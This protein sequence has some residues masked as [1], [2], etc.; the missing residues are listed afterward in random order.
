MTAHRLLSPRDFR[1]MP[2]KNGGG[3]TAEIVS[4]DARGQYGTVR[5]ARL[6]RRD[7]AGRPFSAWPGIDR[8]FVLLGGAGVVLTQGGIDVGEVVARHEP[9]RFAGDEASS[10]RLVDGPARAFNLMVRRGHARGTS[11]S[12][13]ARRR[14]RAVPLRRLLRGRGGERVPAAGPRADRDRRGHALL[15]DGEDRLASM[16][17]NPIDTGAVAIVAALDAASE[18]ATMP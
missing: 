8:T 14:S 15:V 16:H 13:T 1:H 7:R 10:C 6:D 2:W 4:L 11:S 5:R 18:P 12:R 3:R 17:V 9:V